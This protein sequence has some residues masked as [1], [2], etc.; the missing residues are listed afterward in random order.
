MSSEERNKDGTDPDEGPLAEIGAAARQA[1]ILEHGTARHAATD[2]TGVVTTADKFDAV[3]RRL[4]E[5]E[6]RCGRLTLG[7]V[8]TAIVAAA[9]VVLVIVR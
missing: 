6:S 9:G 4:D 3:T 2:H 1:D 8:L 7:L 5:L